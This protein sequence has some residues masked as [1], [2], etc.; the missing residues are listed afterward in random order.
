MPGMSGSEVLEMLKRRDPGLP[1]VI[2][3]GS[4]LEGFC[5][6]LSQAD[7]C[8]PKTTNFAP[9]LQAVLS[10]GSGAKGRYGS[11]TS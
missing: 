1:V 3:T 7:A 9:L 5:E 11:L 4:P 6:E 10:L 2:Y 8:I